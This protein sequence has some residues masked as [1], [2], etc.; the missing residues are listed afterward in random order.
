[1]ISDPKIQE[2][3]KRER[4]WDPQVRWKVLQDTI[5]WADTQTAVQR[6]TPAGRLEEQARKLRC[7]ERASYSV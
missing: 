3:V 7:R 2:E 1:M 5:T 4:S 6:N